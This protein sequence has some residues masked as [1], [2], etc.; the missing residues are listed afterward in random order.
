MSHLL[1]IV[2]LLIVREGV[3]HQ[4]GEKKDVVSLRERFPRLAGLFSEQVVTMGE[5]CRWGWRVG[6]DGW[7]WR[8]PLCVGGGIVERVL[9]SFQ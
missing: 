2:R 3:R 4:S 8:L 1:F 9:W 7:S 5:M 6:G